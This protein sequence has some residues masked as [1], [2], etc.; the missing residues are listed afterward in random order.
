MQEGSGGPPKRGDGLLAGQP[1]DVH[2]PD[3]G[4]SIGYVATHAL[5]IGL[6]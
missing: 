4:E 1:G 2:Q 5:F 6:K 3:V